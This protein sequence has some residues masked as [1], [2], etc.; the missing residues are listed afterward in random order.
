MESEVILTHEGFIRSRGWL[1]ADAACTLWWKRGDYDLTSYKTLSGAYQDEIERAQREGIELPATVKAHLLKRAG[2]TVNAGGLLWYQQEGE[3]HGG[4]YYTLRDAYRIQVH[5]D[6]FE[7]T[8]E[9]PKEQQRF[10]AVESFPPSPASAGYP[11][12]EDSTDEEWTTCAKCHGS[13]K[14]EVE[15]PHASIERAIAILLQAH[16]KMDVAQRELA[17][18]E[19]AFKRIGEQFLFEERGK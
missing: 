3:G 12:A 1:P 4:V 15:P 2:W 7:P 19:N 16:T 8:P 6:R 5:R 11:Y 13:G 18:A 17:E 9:S 14:T 10:D